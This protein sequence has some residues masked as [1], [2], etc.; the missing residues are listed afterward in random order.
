MTDTQSS[1]H[2]EDFAIAPR[3]QFWVE[4]QPFL[5]AHGY[6]LRPRYDP[7][8]VPS[9]KLPSEKPVNPY[10]AEDAKRIFVRGI[11]LYCGGN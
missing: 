5:L 8:W 6:R 4:Q 1:H 3:E 9:W 2:L 7:A 10:D 11:N